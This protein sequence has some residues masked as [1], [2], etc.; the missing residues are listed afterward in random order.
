[1][2]VEAP[3]A[4]RHKRTKQINRFL[5]K[6][7]KQ[8]KYYFSFLEYGGNGNVFCHSNHQKQTAI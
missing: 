2:K 7:A 8:N 4:V 6:H 5:S 3:T 1:M